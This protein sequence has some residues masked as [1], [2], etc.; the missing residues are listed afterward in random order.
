MDDPA[1]QRR[2]LAV[3]RARIEARSDPTHPPAPRRGAHD[4]WKG[5]DHD[6][7]HLRPDG[8]DQRRAGRGDPP[9]ARRRPLQLDLVALEKP[10]RTPAETDEMIHR[11]PCVALALG[12]RRAAGQPRPRRVAVLAGVRD[13]R[14]RRARPVARPP[15]RGDQRGDR[16]RRGARVVGPRRG[17][18]GDGPGVVRGGRHRQRRALEG[19]GGRGARRDRR[20][21]RPEPIEQDLATLPG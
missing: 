7:H 3:H 17:L 11:R 20:R 21:R 9:P 12:T 8:R 6:E 19:E 10:D 16:R 14:P 13:A 5:P 18:R 15:L 4:R 1:E 2:R